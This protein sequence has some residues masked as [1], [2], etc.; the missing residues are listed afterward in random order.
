MS[1][2]AGLML[3]GVCVGFFAA[4]LLVMDAMGWYW[5]PLWFAAESFGNYIV[6]VLV[7]L[8][9]LSVPAWAAL[10]GL[11]QL[12][13]EL[14]RG[15]VFTRKNIRRLGM[16]SGCCFAVTGI[17]LVCLVWMLPLSGLLPPEQLI[18]LILP[19]AAAL[20]GLIVRI[21]KNVFEQAAA[22]KDELDYTV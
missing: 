12:L 8:Y 22:M 3:S 19:V 16:I 5:I 20:M 2:N 13:R 7:M 11:W 15:E 21:V 17:T 1:R 10:A 14:G 6:P 4:V 18:L 9:A